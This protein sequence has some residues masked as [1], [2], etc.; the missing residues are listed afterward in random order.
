MEKAEAE[1]AAAVVISAAIEAE[2]AQLSDPDEKSEFLAT[3]GLEEPGLNKVIR[4]GYQLLG[5]ITFF[6]V[7]PKEARAWTVEKGATASEAA[8]VIHTNFQRGLDRKST[9]L[10]SS[11]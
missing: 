7:G 9:R 6:T 4:A 11:H 2:L 3:L 8:G 5:L 1:G 10:N